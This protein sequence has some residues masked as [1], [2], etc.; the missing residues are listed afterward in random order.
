[1]IAWLRIAR[2]VRRR[3]AKEAAEADKR[4]KRT[5]AKT[6]PYE[7]HRRTLLRALAGYMAHKHRNDLRTFHGP[8]WGN[9]RRLGAKLCA[10]DV[11]IT[12]NYDSTL[13]R[14]L[15]ELR[16]WTPRDGY[17]FE[18]AFWQSAGQS[19]PV[20]FSSSQVKILHLHGALWVV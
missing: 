11:V 2:H 19:T 10:G 8:R 13:K 1:M 14:I 18:S 3:E 4:Y 17:G 6:S 16:K 12:F 15:L 9:L 5:H 7:E 20:E